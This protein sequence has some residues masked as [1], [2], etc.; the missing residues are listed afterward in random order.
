MLARPDDLRVPT[1]QRPGM[2]VN[3][4]CFCGSWFT[5]RVEYQKALAMLAHNAW[6]KTC[7]RT[8]AAKAKR[9]RT[10]KPKKKA[11]GAV[12]RQRAR[13]AGRQ[14]A[15]RWRWLCPACLSMPPVGLQGVC[16]GCLEV[17]EKSCRGKVRHDTETVAVDV[18][19]QMREK[20]AG[21]WF[22]PYGCALCGWW[23]V[24]T[25]VG[26]VRSK[27]IRFTV[28]VLVAAA[29]REWLADLRMAWFE[30]RSGRR[31]PSHLGGVMY[32]GHS[33]A[34][35]GSDRRHR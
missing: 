26:R 8:C 31:R 34:G 25:G 14:A 4:E 21:G 27:V 24:G 16:D 9:A 28:G 19:G 33:A 6:P 29:D 10:G 11:S 3:G 2:W 18:A 22:Q 7:S 1:V 13:Y 23:H 35:S 20:T 5:V 17:V 32:P 15:R 30:S 12:A